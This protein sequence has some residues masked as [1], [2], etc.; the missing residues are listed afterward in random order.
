MDIESKIQE[1]TLFAQDNI[2]VS[3]VICL[4]IIYL[5]F[6]HPKIL[7]TVIIFFVVANGLAW[8]FDKLAKAGLG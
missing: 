4:F 8:L 5:L 6:R 3:V 7:L 2:L 1:L